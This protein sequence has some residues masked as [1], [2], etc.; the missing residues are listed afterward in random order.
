MKTPH[1]IADEEHGE[2]EIML[3][4]EWEHYSA[5]L[6][7]DLLNDWLHDLEAEYWKSVDGIFR[8]ATEAAHARA[9]G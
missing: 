7:A 8:E 9:G 3:P 1:L 5:L 6:R 4:P 2:G